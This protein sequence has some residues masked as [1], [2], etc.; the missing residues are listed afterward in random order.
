MGKKTP[1]PTRGQPKVREDQNSGLI[2]KAEG[3]RQSA[4]AKSVLDNRSHRTRVPSSSSAVVHA[5]SDEEWG[6]PCLLEEGSGF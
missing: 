1:S 6:R 2:A 4:R 5:E 3:P